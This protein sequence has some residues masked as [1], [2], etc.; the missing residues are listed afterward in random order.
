MKRLRQFGLLSPEERNMFVR[1]WLL[2]PL[3]RLSVAGLG[4][5][6]TQRWLAMGSRRPAM[7]G[8]TS[9]NDA[10][11]TTCRL[12]RAAA[13]HHVCRTACL[14]RALV[15]W[16]LLEQ[17]GIESRVELGAAR[18]GGIFEAHAWVGIGGRRLDPSLQARDAAFVPFRSLAG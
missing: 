9:R 16:A 17:Q 13:D 5:R 3:V 7:P 12:V 4:L 10:A 1:A 11:D 2:L 14:P 15:V 18:P 6:R 8:S